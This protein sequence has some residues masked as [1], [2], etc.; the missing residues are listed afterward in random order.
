M[1]LDRT[2][3]ETV[4]N[5]SRTIGHI[6]TPGPHGFAVESELVGHLPM[7]ATIEA[8]RRLLFDVDQA[9]KH[10]TE[11]Q[12]VYIA[13]QERQ[14][15]AMEGHGRAVD[16]KLFKDAENTLAAAERRLAELS[17]VRSE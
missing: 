6:T 13:L 5:S 4:T 14:E 8:A 2:F 9:L 16:P 17:G 7:T 1:K 3:V 15:A 11:M 12:L 10:R